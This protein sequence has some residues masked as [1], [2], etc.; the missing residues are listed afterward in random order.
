MSSEAAAVLQQIDDIENSQDLDALI[1]REVNARRNKK[2]A[3]LTLSCPGCGTKNPNT[4][5]F[6]SE[7]GVKLKS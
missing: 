2:A 4:N 7:C 3:S 6:C 5:K 1:R